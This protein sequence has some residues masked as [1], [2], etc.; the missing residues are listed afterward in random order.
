MLSS[1]NSTKTPV[2]QT[3]YSFFTKQVQIN[4]SLDIWGA[5]L[6]NVESLATMRYQQVFHVTWS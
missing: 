3:A 4:F 6:R 1:G 2:F 5:N